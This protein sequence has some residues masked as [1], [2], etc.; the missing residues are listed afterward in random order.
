MKKKGMRCKG[1]RG[2]GRRAMHLERTRDLGF[3]K[4]GFVSS[5]LRQRSQVMADRQTGKAIE[6]EKV[7]ESLG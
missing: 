7:D 2:N 6:R 3:R 5:G 4:I 1:I